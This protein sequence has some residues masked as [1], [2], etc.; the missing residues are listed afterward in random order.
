MVVEE[1]VEVEGDWEVVVGEAVVAVVGGAGGS[2]A[3]GGKGAVV[4]TA[5][6]ASAPSG[7]VTWEVST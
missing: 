2:E 6:G 4:E 5:W 7:E 1:E 3:K